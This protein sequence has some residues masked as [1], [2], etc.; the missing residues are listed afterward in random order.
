MPWFKKRLFYGWVMVVAFFI[1]ATTLSGIQLTFGVFFKSIESEFNLTRAATSAILST[2]VLLAGVLAFLLG[3]ALDKYGPRK[4]VLF[5]GIFT[6]LGL[7]LT[8]QTT[9][10]WQLFITYGLLLSIGTG[11]VYVVPMSTVS[12]WFDRK[13]GLAL[14][15]TGAGLGLGIVVIAPLATYLISNFDWRVAYMVIG[16]IAWVIVIPLSRLL[17]R[18]PYEIGALPDGVDL[19]SGD[20]HVQKPK[21][22]SGNIQSP[23]RLL[24]QVLKSRNLWLI[25]FA[26]FFYASCAFLVL[27]HLVPH[28]TDMDFSSE[29]GAALLGLIGGI[30]IIGTV[31]M[32]IASDRIGRRAAVMICT[33]LQ[34]GT[35]IWLVWSQELWMLY[36]FAIVYGFT[37]GGFISSMGALIGSTFGLGKIGA[38]FGVLEIGFGIGAAI[39]P[40]IGGLIFDVNDSY[41]SAFLLG[42]AVMLIAT[43]LIALVKREANGNFKGG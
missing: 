15:I 17:R 32:G 31:L 8:S 30:S 4:I 34:A 22:E 13:R 38:V 28:V 12:R 16:L 2:N 10:Q 23:G 24:L 25:M 33:L 9:A 26:R 19:D 41:F 29:E 35:M 40:F 5:M 11:A 37:Q 27:T 1:V 7:L 3:L 18:D 39:G 43:L 42:A 20:I 14:G 21:N 6:G 36:L